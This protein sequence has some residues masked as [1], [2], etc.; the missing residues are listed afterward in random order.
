MWE[1]AQ[2]VLARDGDV[3]I[4]THSGT[5]HVNVSPDAIV[6]VMIMPPAPAVR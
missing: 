6:D 2:L 3:K 4:E 5:L 1:K